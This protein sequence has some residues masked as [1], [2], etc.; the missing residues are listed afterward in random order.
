MDRYLKLY[1]DMK[2]LAILA[3]AALLAACSQEKPRTL[4][5]YY[6][7]TGAT[8]TVAE[9]ISNLLGADIE[10][11]EAAVP[12]E[13]SFDDIV[14]RCLVERASGTLPEMKPLSS[15]LSGY[16]VIFLGYPIWFG[17]CASP[18]L[19][20]L[21]GIDLSGK[22]VV[23][24][25]TFGSGGLEAGAEEVRKH[26]PDADVREGYG[27]RNARIAKAPAELRRFLVA[28]GFLDGKVEE[29]PEFSTPVSVT[30]QEEEVFNSACGDYEFPLG[31][32]VS[33][34]I[35]RISG[36][37]EYLFDAESQ[38]EQGNPS[39]S[40]IYVTALDGHEPEFTRVVR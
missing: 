21:E 34:S 33:V 30:A 4:V 13:G 25:C 5:L 32:P 36:G 26:Q 18:M 27:V 38:D 39:A 9:E 23:P 10:E 37:V 2:R 3:A 12:Y 24:F 11:V 20:L 1:S 28:S 16:D 6:S 17:T 19:S 14:R 29:L 35:R 8:E 7:A 22:V 15:D 40:K 31:T